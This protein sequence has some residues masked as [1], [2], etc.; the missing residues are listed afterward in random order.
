LKQKRPL[1]CK[2]RPNSTHDP[3]NYEEESHKPSENASPT[4]GGRMTDAIAKLLFEQTAEL[5]NENTPGI[6]EELKN[7]AEGKL[8]V[9]M[10]FKLQLIGS[11]IHVNSTVSYSRKFSGDAEAWAQLEDPTQP[12]LPLSES[13]GVTIKD[14][15]GYEVFRGS[16]ATTADKVKQKGAKR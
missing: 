6:A 4:K 7:D 8:T 9:G 1:S 11:R 12:G 16:D 13:V 5:L 10:S 15:M 2:Q 14:D 3:L